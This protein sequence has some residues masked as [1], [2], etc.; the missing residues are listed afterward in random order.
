MQISDYVENVVYCVV[1]TNSDCLKIKKQ[2]DCEIGIIF[3]CL[4]CHIN[5]FSVI[6]EFESDD[7]LN[8]KE[9]HHIN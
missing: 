4:R 7:L 5:K 2:I 3:K 9:S 8:M 1:F 6:D